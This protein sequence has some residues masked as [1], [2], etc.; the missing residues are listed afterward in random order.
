MFAHIVIEYVV[1][2]WRIAG[3]AF[4]GDVDIRPAGRKIHHHHRT[5]AND[6]MKKVLRRGAEKEAVLHGDNA[7]DVLARVILDVQEGCV[8]QCTATAAMISESR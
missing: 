6:A 4:G 3:V 1:Y 2:D 8:S 5:W 7:G